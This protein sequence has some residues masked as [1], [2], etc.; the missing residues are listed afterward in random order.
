MTTALEI[1]QDA[2]ERMNVYS[3]GDTL[4]A[5]DAAKG[6]LVLNRMMEGWS[7][8]ALTC[9][10]ISQQ[11]FTLV[12]GT[13]R[14]S[15]G[16]G[17][18]IAQTR[19][20]RILDGPGRAFI[21]DAN[22]NKY[23]IEVIP[24]DQWNEIGNSS[25]SVTSDYPDTL[26]YDPQYPLGYLN[27]FPTPLLS[28]VAYWESYLQFSSF[29]SLS[30]TVSLPPGY[31]DAMSTNLTLYLW[32]YYKPDNSVPSPLLTEIAS[33]AKAKIKRTN[34]R[35]N[36]AEMEPELVRAGGTGYNIYSDRFTSR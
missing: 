1:I 23:G 16:S 10:A 19:P 25:S 29:S 24:Q 18:T 11:S 33:S 28:V 31:E 3:P 8:E 9:F 26:F 22:G 21:L 35:P 2:F 13:S 7:N 14:Y 32:P 27:F 6:L 15:I 20:L 5:A 17:G 4:S 30:G 36:I 12:A 34:L